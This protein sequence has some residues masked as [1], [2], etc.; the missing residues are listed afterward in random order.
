MPVTC[1]EARD[2]AMDVRDYIT[3]VCG[4]AETINFQLIGDNPDEMFALA[5]AYA[6]RLRK[7]YDALGEDAPNVITKGALVII[8]YEEDEA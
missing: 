3:R 7:V 5:R 1:E 6:E 2:I 8:T 4:G